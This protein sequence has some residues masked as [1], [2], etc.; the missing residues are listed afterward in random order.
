MSRKGRQARVCGPGFRQATVL[1]NLLMHV[2]ISMFSEAAAE[3]LGTKKK[4]NTLQC[5]LVPYKTPTE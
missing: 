3:K 5:I 4:V 1:K 2:A